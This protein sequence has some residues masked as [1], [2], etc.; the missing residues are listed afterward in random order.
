MQGRGEGESFAG[1]GTA[2][3]GRARWV[4]MNANTSGADGQTGSPLAGRDRAPMSGWRRGSTGLGLHSPP[5]AL[6]SVPW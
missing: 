6:T 3:E 5:G 4:G 1:A 2:E